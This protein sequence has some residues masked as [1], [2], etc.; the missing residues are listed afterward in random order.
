MK[1]FSI[2][3]I[4]A[5]ALIVT[6][7]QTAKADLFGGDVAVL[8]QILYQAVQQLIQLRAILNNG[9]DTLGL[10]QDINR[11]INDSLGLLKSVGVNVDP[12]LYGNLMNAQDALFKIQS[13]YGIIVPSLDAGVQKDTDQS[14][15]EA[16]TLNNS[17]YQYSNEIDQIGEQVK[18]FSHSVSPGGAQKLTAQTLGVML[19]VM[20]QQLRAQATGLKMQAQN[21][22]L[23]NK[24]EK[25]S[26]KHFLE[27]SDS[28]NTAL[29]TEN[30]TFS[31]PRF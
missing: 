27:V 31:I 23:S 30:P 24:K 19:H 11:G 3:I 29:K 8:V 26:T 2:S 1:K 20:N 14:V 6:T 21:L 4:T 9:Q 12:G 28:L 25:D 18:Q 5:F 15:A 22:A 13:I 17:L 16:I 7:P 10:M